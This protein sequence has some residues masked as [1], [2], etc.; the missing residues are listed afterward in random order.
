MSIRIT[1]Y[2]RGPDPANLHII[3]QLWFTNT[4]SWPLPT[5]P[6]PSVKEVAKGVITAKHSTL[7]RTHL[8]CS[9]SPPPVNARGEYTT[10]GQGEEGEEYDDSIVPELIFTENDTNFARLYGG[11]NASPYV[12]DAFHDHIIEGH[13]LK[14]EAEAAA[15]AQAKAQAEAKAK[16]SST[17]N[18]NG[19][20]TGNGVKIPGIVDAGRDAAASKLLDAAEEGFVPASSPT[21]PP[22]SPLPSSSAP[23]P[24]SPSTTPTPS[25]PT[26]PLP[27][28]TNPQKT[29]TKSAAHYSFTDVPG[30]GGCVVVRLKL[31]PKSPA[32]DPAINDEEVFDQCID[33][34]RTEADE[35]YHRLAGPGVGSDDLRA[36]MRQALGGMMWYVFL[37]AMDWVFLD[38]GG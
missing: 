2:N 14:V 23:S 6:R 8:Y 9:P 38:S 37:S 36:I 22:S 13:R 3:P 24:P 32:Q 28:Y 34:R 10:D 25:T 15:Q 27:E 7:G 30:R 20:G 29:G 5:P 21:L 17:A 16:A 12:K 33:E 4:W 26:P 35:F 18:G 19:N 1:A 11:N 31:T